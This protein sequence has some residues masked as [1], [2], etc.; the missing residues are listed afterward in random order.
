MGLEMKL[1]VFGPTGKTG[2]HVVEQALARGYVVRAVARRPES[3]GIEH[4][5]LAV[6]GGDVLAPEEWAH[7]LAGVDAVIS[8]IGV[9]LQRTPTTVYSAGTAGI[10]TA[11]ARN[12]IRR[13]AVVSA[14]PAGDWRQASALKRLVLYPVLQRLFGASYDDM[15]RMERILVDSPVDWTILRPVYLTNGPPRGRYRLSVDGPI[16][17]ATSISRAD[18]ATALLEAVLDDRLRRRAIEVAW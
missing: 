8:A 6:I 17:R 16:K 14:A 10:L 4:E 1:A 5:N 12:A 3:I 18:L 13:L 9:G 2:H 7:Q 11:M 15:R